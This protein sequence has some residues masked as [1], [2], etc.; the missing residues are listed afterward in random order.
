[1][2]LKIETIDQYIAGFPTEIQQVLEKMRSTIKEIVPQATESIKYGIPTFELYGNLV[3]FA[4]YKSHIGFYPT[5]SGILAFKEELSRYKSAR[6]SVQFPLTEVLPIELITQI[7]HYR[8]NENMNK[9]QVKGK[10]FK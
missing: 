5:P 8:V 10:K 2:D 9:P 7:V 6:G 1:M 3:H 4:G